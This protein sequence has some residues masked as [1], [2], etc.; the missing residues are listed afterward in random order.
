M[1]EFAQ[2]ATVRIELGEDELLGAHLLAR[3]Q[4]VAADDFAQ[5]ERVLRR[6]LRHGLETHLDAAGMQWPP[7]ADDLELADSVAR[8]IATETTPD[9]TAHTLPINGRVRLVAGAITTALIV[10]L[11]GGY[12]MR[13]SWTGFAGNNQVWDWMQLLL[14]PIALATFPL[15]LR[16]SGYI[17]PARRRALEAVAAAFI[18]FV[19]VGYLNP[20]RWAGFRGHS[21]WDWMTLLILPVSIVAVRAWPQS[22]RDVHRRHIVAATLLGVGFIATIIGGYVAGWNWTGYQGNT[23]WDWLT[24]VLGPV[25]VTTI[26]VPALVKVLTGGAD[27]RAERERV[28][29]ARDEALRVAQARIANPR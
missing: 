15:W 22:G 17:S 12:G 5:F 21:L 16:F 11:I 7:T 29:R 10:L 4:G 23:L 2:G 25:A 20:L 24:L 8:E 14:L 27:E 19:V 1:A 28:R 18:V 6:V 3:M 26:L 13:W 9:D